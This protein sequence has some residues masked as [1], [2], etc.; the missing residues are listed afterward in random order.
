MASDG[1]DLLYRG[2]AGPLSVEMSQLS[3][4]DTLL[5][6]DQL[7][8]H[9]DGWPLQPGAESAVNFSCKPLYYLGKAAQ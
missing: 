2:R 5:L 7:V 1:L 4:R 8:V 3:R 9:T 6:C